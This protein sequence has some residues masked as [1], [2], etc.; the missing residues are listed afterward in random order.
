MAPGKIK[1]IPDL[2]SEIVDAV[3]RNRLAVFIGAGVSRVLG[4]AGWD[5]LSEGLMKRCT[6]TEKSDGSPCLGEQDAGVLRGYDNKK[7]ITI[8]KEILGENRHEEAFFDEVERSLKAD[9]DKLKTKNIYQ[10]LWRLR[11]LF[12]TTNMDEHFDAR[13]TPSKIA[14]RGEDFV[15]E[16]DRNKLYH[17]HGKISDR[18]SVVLTIPRYITQYNAPEL[19]KFLKSIFA[20][21]TVLFVGYGME[22]FELLDFIIGKYRPGDEIELKHHIL[23]PFK[24]EEERTL[25]FEEYYYHLMGINVIPYQI[26]DGDYERLY[27]VIQAW[28]WE[29]NQ[30]TVYLHESFDDLEESVKDPTPERIEDALQFI[31]NDA[32]HRR[33]LFKLL[34]GAANPQPW[35][36]TLYGCGY[37]DPDHNP[38]PQVV[39]AG[40]YTVPYWEAL[41]FLENVA[42]KNLKAPSEDITD[43]ILMILENIIY[44]K[45]DA[46]ER[47][48]N[49]H[50]DAS[51]ARVIF[52]LPL[53][54]ITS[55][56][57]EFARDALK[58]SREA[59]HIATAIEEVALPRAT[60]RFTVE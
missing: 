10:E 38:R 22:E 53:E 2:P 27:D 19:Q 16:L 24:T 40:Y 46:G 8:C 15:K 23:K 59:I 56:H 39:K 25:R 54:M 50:T 13:F 4:C 3:N 47:I 30:T 60:S 29:I 26:G 20:K 36:E 28:N 42:A 52:S 32:P 33:H 1:Q 43:L 51:M 58:A 45:T 55:A 44:Y 11:A 5:D 48:E 14:C 57:Y 6:M 9:P 31:Q 12:I 7:R 34:R 21:Y 49:H 41:G 35:L 18:A 37:L 17:I